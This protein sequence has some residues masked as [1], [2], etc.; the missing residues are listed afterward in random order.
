M[1]N[2]FELPEL[3]IVWFEDEDIITSSGPEDETGETGNEWWG[4]GN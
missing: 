4:T 1:K 3:I 2:K